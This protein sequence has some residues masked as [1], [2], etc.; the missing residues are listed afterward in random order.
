[1]EL[2]RLFIDLLMSIKMY[3]C[4]ND[5]NIIL[6]ITL[7]TITTGNSYTVNQYSGIT[8]IYFRQHNI[9]NIK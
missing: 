2:V 9:H 7:I 3:Y 5:K 8:R 6:M 1:M 4:T